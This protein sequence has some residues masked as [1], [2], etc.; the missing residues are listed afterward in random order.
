MAAEQGDSDACVQFASMLAGGV[1][2][3]RDDSAATRLFRLAAEQGNP[4]GQLRYGT[5]VLAENPIEGVKFLLMAAEYGI[6]QA[7]IGLG[8]ALMGGTGIAA[9][10][11]EAAEWF[12]IAAE[13]GDPEAPIEYAR[14]LRDGRGITRNPTEAG[15]YF[16]LATGQGRDR[17][18]LL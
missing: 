10:A 15:R 17:E 12:A 4:L 3:P 5:A 1:G 9:K 14:C 8:R 2:V 6:P 18:E 16:S 7:Q 13:Q 11:V